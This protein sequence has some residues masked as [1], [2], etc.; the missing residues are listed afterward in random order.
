VFQLPVSEAL[1]GKQNL[2][3]FFNLAGSGAISSRKRLAW[4]R[5]KV[6]HIHAECTTITHGTDPRLV[7]RNKASL[8]YHD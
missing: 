7:A 1:A 5:T 8:N 4:D 6:K 3:G 2:Q